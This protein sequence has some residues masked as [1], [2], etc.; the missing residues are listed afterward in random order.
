MRRPLRIVVLGILGR[1]PVAGVAWQGLHYLEGLRRLGHDVVY[2]EDTGR[3]TSG[4]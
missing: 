3:P 2:L 4:G 1:D